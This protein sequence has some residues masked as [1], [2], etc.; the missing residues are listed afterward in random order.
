[1]WRGTMEDDEWSRV[2]C[3]CLRGRRESEVD[4]TGA[5]LPVLGEGARRRRGSERCGVRP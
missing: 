1:M 2:G 4:L 3:K 5:H